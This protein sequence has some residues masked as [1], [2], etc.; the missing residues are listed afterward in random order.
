VTYVHRAGRTARYSSSGE[1]L[2]VLLESE[3][4][5]M[6]KQLSAHKIPINKIEVNPAKLTSVQK[7]MAAYLAS[8][9]NLKESAQRAFQSYIKSI[10]LMRNKAVFDVTKL[11]TE[12]FAE[13][14]GLAV[15][16]RVRFLEKQ[17][18]IKEAQKSKKKVEVEEE[19]VAVD[20]GSVDIEVKEN[21]PVKT[22]ST[23]TKFADSDDDDDDNDI[24]TVKRKDHTIATGGELGD[25]S[26]EDED[27][28]LKKIKVV[29]K[30]AVAK[31][32]LKKKIQANSRLQFDEE[33]ATVSDG[34]TN[35]ASEVGKDY[36]KEDSD[37]IGGGIDIVK[38]REV[39]KEEDKH[40]K[41]M[42]RARI[43]EMKQKLKKKEKEEKKRK[44]EEKEQGNEGEQEE[45]FD[46][47]DSSDGE[48]VDLSW[49]PDP[50]KVYG[51]K[52]EDEKEFFEESDD[53][54]EEGKKTEVKVG[55]RKI[56]V[57]N[58]VIPKKA[59]LEEDE[60]SSRVLDTGLSLEDDE[61]L[62]LQLL[63]K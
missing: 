57:I 47:E 32:I 4:G 41:V 58:K 33:G 2:L 37:R 63:S 5:A 56:T 48:S 25:V 50:D 28:N 34:L 15:P 42:E 1:S 20:D 17:M 36:E 62:A 55:K 29:T 13:S 23:I 26:D 46:D 61:D 53:S 52:E 7:K 9:K 6:L 54:D 18:K 19:T 60:D 21:V 35:K 45:E 59:K 39:L 51:E 8:D 30:A 24:L 49:L 12:E 3:E 31:K 43:R 38:A 27:L 16:P 44:R 11:K 14:L 22:T 40:D 10:Y